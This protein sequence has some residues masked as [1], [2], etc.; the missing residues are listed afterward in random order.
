MVRF[1]V[2]MILQDL[3]V[4]YYDDVAILCLSV[5]V[6]I[7]DRDILNLLPYTNGVIPMQFVYR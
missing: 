5:C 1:V 6:Y 7:D 4:L 2:V 3:L